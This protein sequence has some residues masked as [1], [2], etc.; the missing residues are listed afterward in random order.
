MFRRLRGALIIVRVLLPFL[1]AIGLILA[2]WVTAGRVADAT[3]DYGERLG[4]QLDNVRAAVS[5]ANQGITALG[6]YATSAAGAAEAVF[7]RVS[8]LADSVTIPLPEIVIP[9][10]TVPVINR[11][12]DLPDIRLGSGDLVIPIP[13]IEPLQDL[14]GRLADAGRQLGDDVSKVA[15]L[16]DVPPHLPQAATDTAAY[17]G[18]VRSA[19]SRWLITV[20]VLL[21]A[22]AL[23]WLAAAVRPIVTDLRH[24][25]S[26]VRGRDVSARS[27][28]DLL[29]RMRELQREVA[30]L[31]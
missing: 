26:M 28:D 15:G 30:E 20:A 31:R 11:T 14:A 23:L 21:T 12:I 25:W 5:E 27:V 8:D 17:A 29:Y 10:F 1:M 18:D 4:A 3:R 16:A 6:R 13:G 9:E 22:G 19:T 7:G 2:T 24:G